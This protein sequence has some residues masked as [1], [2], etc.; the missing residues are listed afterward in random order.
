MQGWS[1]FFC[2][3]IFSTLKCFGI[4]SQKISILQEWWRVFQEKGQLQ[5][6]AIRR[7]VSISSNWRSTRPW[8]WSSQGLLQHCKDPE[9]V[10]LCIHPAVNPYWPWWLSP[11]EDHQVA[12]L[13]SSLRQFL[14]KVCLIAYAKRA[15]CW[16]YFGEVKYN[17]WMI[18]Q[19][20]NKG[21]THFECWAKEST[22]QAYL[23]MAQVKLVARLRFFCVI[24]LKGVLLQS[25]WLCDAQKS[26]NS[27]KPQLLH[28][29]VYW[30]LLF[31]CQ[32]GCCAPFKGALE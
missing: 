29:H 17:L 10:R 3:N 22:L 4:Q 11:W 30:L 31:T 14:F 15:D 23:A 8:Q 2:F 24:A 12:F 27:L 7:E 32:V 25:L 19:L 28:F 18:S 9:S 21:R 1:V 6:P 16:A 13:F 20:Y 5:I 26:V